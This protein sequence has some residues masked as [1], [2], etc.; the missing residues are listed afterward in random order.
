MTIESRTVCVECGVERTQDDAVACEQCGARAVVIQMQ[1]T[2]ELA[3]A[4][5]DNFALKVA[6]K[7]KSGPGSKSRWQREVKQTHEAWM[8]TDTIVERTLD[9]DR[10]SK[11]ISGKCVDVATGEALL[12]KSGPLDEH[13]GHGSAKPRVGQ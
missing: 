7:L 1:V 5:R 6:P 3:V 10:V 8:Q 12:D 11:T 2:D 13:T 9:T 4:I